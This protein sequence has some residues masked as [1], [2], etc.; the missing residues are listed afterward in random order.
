MTKPKK[1]TKRREGQSA[2]KAMLERKASPVTM[3]AWAIKDLRGT[4]WVLCK[5]AEPSLGS[6]LNDE[7]PSPEAKPVRVRCSPL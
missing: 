5:W 4:R 1:V 2:S 3:W 7:L 6:L